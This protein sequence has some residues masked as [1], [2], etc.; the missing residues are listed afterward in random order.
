MKLVET[1]VIA[2]GYL[3][4]VVII[5]FGGYLYH[6]ATVADPVFLKI[7]CVILGIVAQL[8][9]L[10]GFWVFSRRE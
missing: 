4:S 8:L 6:L 5:I 7:T 2:V 1:F 10:S 3:L 9:G